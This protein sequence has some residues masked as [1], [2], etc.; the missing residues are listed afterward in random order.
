MID[1]FVSRKWRVALRV[2]RSVLY[3]CVVGFGVSGIILTPV[4]ISGA[5]GNGLTEWWSLL[6]ACGAAV[7]IVGAVSGRYRIEWSGILP[8]AGGT[9]MYA[10]TVWSIAAFDSGTRSAQ[11]FIATGLFLALCYRWTEI[12]ARSAMIRSQTRKKA[13]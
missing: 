7:S 11:A 2:V 5:V 12:A 6:A 8:A 9:L 1:S 10:M 3:V 13:R 4:T